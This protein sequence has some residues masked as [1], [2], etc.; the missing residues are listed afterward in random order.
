[1]EA[2]V[3]LMGLATAFAAAVL[4][5]PD[6][7]RAASSL[8]MVFLLT[9]FALLSLGAWF[10]GA[11]QVLLGAGAVAILA[12]YAAITSKKR[13]EV[14]RSR[15]AGT[16]AALALSVLG[17]SMGFL[18]LNTPGTFTFYSSDASKIAEVLFEDV[19]LTVALS[20][21]LIVALIASAYIVRYVFLREVRA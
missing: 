12:L 15:S 9:G 5:D 18:T 21:L 11:M 3:L 20:V 10:V 8:V 14:L 2:F 16:I 7:V 17:I 19:G 6:I 13:K 4:W 1:M